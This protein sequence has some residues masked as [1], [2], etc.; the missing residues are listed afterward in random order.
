MPVPQKLLAFVVGLLL[1]FVVGF[2]LGDA[3]DPVLDDGSP[4]EAPAQHQEH[5]EP[6]P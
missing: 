3:I 6:V 4:S 2:G 1:A 5:E